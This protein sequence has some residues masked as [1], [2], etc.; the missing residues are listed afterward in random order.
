MRL[1]SNLFVD[2]ALHPRVRNLTW[3]T[4]LLWLG[5][6][7][8]IGQLNAPLVGD[9]VMAVPRWPTKKAGLRRN[10]YANSLKW[11]GEMHPLNMHRRESPDV[12][13]S[14]SALRSIDTAENEMHAMLA[15]RAG[16]WVFK[17]PPSNLT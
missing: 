5:S 6:G 10:L 13:D 3:P 9:I 11:E 1:K 2:L 17:N 4:L 16:C 12:G 7:G 14:Q 8:Q 15:H